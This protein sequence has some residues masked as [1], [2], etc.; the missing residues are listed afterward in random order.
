MDLLATL[1]TLAVLSTL[2]LFCGWRG[3][4]PPNILKGPRLM[5][6]RPMMMACVV[7][8]LL[9]TAHLLNLLGLQTGGQTR[10]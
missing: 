9:L 6:W 8:V 3:A 7:A 4:R 1:I 10:Y 2:T 5:P